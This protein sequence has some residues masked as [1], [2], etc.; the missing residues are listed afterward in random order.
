[1]APCWWW[2]ARRVRQNPRPH[3]PHRQPGADPLRPTPTTFWR[4][5]FTNKAAKEMK[6]RIEVLFARAGCPGPSRQIPQVSAGVRA[7]QAQVPGL[8][9]TLPSTC[10]LALST[11]LC[12]RHFCGSTLTSTS[13]PRATPAWTKNFSIFDESDAQSLVKTIVT[14]TLNLD[15]KKFQPP[16]VRFCHQ[17]RQEP[18]AQPRRVRERAAQTTGA[19]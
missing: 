16:L 10:G 2:P 13:D 15:D 9:K 5:T 7:D 6:E 17:Q 19:G 14:Q 3:L 18:E 11:A 1:M 8:Q 12:S 4:V